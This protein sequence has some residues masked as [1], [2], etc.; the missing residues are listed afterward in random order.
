MS[1]IFVAI[2]TAQ[3]LI[4]RYGDIF[5][6]GGL[7]FSPRLL[8]QVLLVVAFMILFEK[9]NEKN[10][11]LSSKFFLFFITSMYRY[12]IFRFLHLVVNKYISNK[13]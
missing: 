4:L 13:K 11:Q 9:D 10:K 12:V 8:L 7:G 3:E 2:T 1:I 5:T 6:S